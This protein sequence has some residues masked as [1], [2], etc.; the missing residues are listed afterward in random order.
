MKYKLKKGGTIKLQT[1]WTTMPSVEDSIEKAWAVQSMREQSREYD[2]YMEDETSARRFSKFKK[3]HPFR[4]AMLASL[5]ITQPMGPGDYVGSGSAF[6]LANEGRFN[7]ARDAEQRDDAQKAKWMLEYG[8]PAY[9]G[10]SSWAARGLLGA[11][12]ELGGG[13][14]ASEGLD[15]LGR[16]G[17]KYLDNRFNTDNKWEDRLGLVGN[18]GG[19]ILGSKF[20][21]GAVKKELGRELYNQWRKYGSA[22]VPNWWA[23]NQMKLDFASDFGKNLSQAQSRGWF[24]SPDIQIQQERLPSWASNY[25]KPV[26]QYGS[27]TPAT[28]TNLTAEEL[29]NPEAFT[30]IDISTLTPQHRGVNLVEKEPI[31]K[32]VFE[33]SPKAKME[34]ARR[35]RTPQPSSKLEKSLY[36]Y[37]KN[38]HPEDLEH[39][40]DYME[41][42]IKSWKK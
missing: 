21:Y 9:I 22:K 25:E 34:A 24:Q 3:E 32:P 17:G 16:V 20:G 35:A 41:E 18:I 6:A 7:A 40:P 26:M 4:A 36:T 14:L 29:A 39:W 42:F 15:K 30:G 38:Y 19:W 37:V 5:M 28:A 23:S 2:R 10:G 33:Q 12:G 8:L 13:W 31:I 11:I 1:A 27:F